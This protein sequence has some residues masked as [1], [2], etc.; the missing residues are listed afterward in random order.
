MEKILNL[1]LPALLSSS[2]V[3]LIVGFLF[4]RRTEII[5]AEVK[6]QFEQNMT[7]YKS[8]YQWKEKAVSEL[9]GQ[10]YMQ[11]SRTKRAFQRYS[12][13]N[14]YLEAKVIKEGNEK[15]RNLL[16]E[17]AYLI[18]SELLEDA[19]LLIE[20]YDVWLEEF[21][22]QRDSEK[23]NLEQKFIF[24]GPKGFKFPEKAE[25]NFKNKYHQIWN[26]LYK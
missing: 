2:V 21:Y 7:I 20:H 6:N 23:P 22:K 26:E 12:A 14:L 11:F 16:L 24:V 25:E 9:L 13:T 10:I 3:A 8:S 15:I 1:L 18:P 17:K 5:T 19:N 4:K